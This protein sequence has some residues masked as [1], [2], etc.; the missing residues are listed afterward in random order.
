MR[1]IFNLV[2]LLLLFFFMLSANKYFVDISKERNEPLFC[3]HIHV[4]I[5][6]DNTQV[7]VIDVLSFFSFFAEE[8]E[9]Y[10]Q[11]SHAKR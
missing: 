4:K 6:R 10:R 1:K 3:K 2:V 7:V 8:H 5:R 11:D 9:A